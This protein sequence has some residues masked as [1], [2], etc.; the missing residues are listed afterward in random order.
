[1]KFSENLVSDRVSLLEQSALVAVPPDTTAGDTIALMRA[2]RCGCV[3]GCEDNRLL[4]IFTE[5]DVLKRVLAAGVDLKTRIDAFMTAHPVTIRP[6]DTVGLVIRRMLDGGYRHLPVV[7]GNGR[8]VGVVSVKGLIHYF[9][10]YFPSTVYNLPPVPG[11]VQ[12][13]REGA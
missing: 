8:A 4:G 7:D 1:M 5:R 9:V 13:S 3:L 6:T 11:Q 2:R 10:E 12:Q